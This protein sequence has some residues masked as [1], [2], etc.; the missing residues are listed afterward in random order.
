MS[1]PT[2][3]V[4]A[5]PRPPVRPKTGRSQLLLDAI[6]AQGG[7]W[8]TGRAKAFYRKAYPSHVYPSTIRRQLQQLAAVGVLAQHEDGHGHRY[9]TLKD[10]APRG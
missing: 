1:I 10:G 8:T 7:Q 6:R 2:P 5:K 9:Y 3:A 4:M